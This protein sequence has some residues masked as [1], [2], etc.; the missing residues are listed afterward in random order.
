[1]MADSQLSCYVHQRMNTYR[2]GSNAQACG[3]QVASERILSR[4]RSCVTRFGA[5][6]SG[7]LDDPI[8]SL[9]RQRSLSG[10][11]RDRRQWRVQEDALGFGPEGQVLQEPA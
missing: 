10:V 3:A 7:D 6:A 1:M 8:A 5:G 9:W 11:L 4:C 2:D